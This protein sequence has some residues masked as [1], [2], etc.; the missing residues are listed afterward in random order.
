MSATALRVEPSG[1]CLQ[2]ENQVKGKGRVLI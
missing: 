1:E 2:G